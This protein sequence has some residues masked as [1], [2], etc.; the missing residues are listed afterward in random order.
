MRGDWAELCILPL[1]LEIQ[2]RISASSWDTSGKYLNWYKIKIVLKSLRLL[3][4]LLPLNLYTQSLFSQFQSL[5]ESADR[6]I[7]FLQTRSSITFFLY[8]IYIKIQIIWKWIIDFFELVEILTVILAWMSCLSPFLS[9]KRQ[10]ISSTEA[11]RIWNLRFCLGKE[12]S[13]VLMS[14]FRFSKQAIFYLWFVS[15]FVRGNDQFQLDLHHVENK[16]K[17]FSGCQCYDRGN[18]ANSGKRMRSNFL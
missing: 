5:Y 14:C 6:F 17:T 13:S 18:M 2:F 16:T 3:I 10:E 15:S 12:L 8:T 7:S 11:A 1:L 4:D 9:I